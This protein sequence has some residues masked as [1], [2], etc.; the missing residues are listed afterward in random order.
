MIE[1]RRGKGLGS[2]IL[3]QG[4]EELH[5]GFGRQCAKKFYVEGVVSVSNDPSNKIARRLLSDTP[6]AITDEVSG[7]AALQYLKLLE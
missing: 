6:T 7:E 2:A 4:M 5:R 3:S 1:S